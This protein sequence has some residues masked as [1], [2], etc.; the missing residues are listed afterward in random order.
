MSW[1][2]VICECVL[3]RFCNEHAVRYRLSQLGSTCL[4]KCIGDYWVDLYAKLAAG[5]GRADTVTP[6]YPA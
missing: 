4:C 2:G 1:L 3:Q 5:D 6:P